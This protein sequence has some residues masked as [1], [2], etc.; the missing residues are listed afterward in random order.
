VNLAYLQPLKSE[1]RLLFP[2]SVFGLGR[3]ISRFLAG[4]PGH[5]RLTLRHLPFA[6]RSPQ[7]DSKIS[8]GGHSGAQ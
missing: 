7:R 3:L 1:A 2:F 5:R 6:G 4:L 8:D